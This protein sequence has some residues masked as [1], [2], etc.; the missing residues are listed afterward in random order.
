MWIFPNS[1][2]SWLKLKIQIK[3]DWKLESLSHAPGKPMN[4]RRNPTP[5][6]TNNY[7]LGIVIE[8]FKSRNRSYYR[9]NSWTMPEALQTDTVRSYP[10]VEC[11]LIL[12][13]DAKQMGVYR[14][15]CNTLQAWGI[16]LAAR[17]ELLMPDD[18]SIFSANKK[19][20]LFTPPLSISCQF[21][22]PFADRRS[23]CYEV[24]ES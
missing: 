22:L 4:I 6:E 16:N 21:L 18:F 11:K 5:W 14:W 15:S 2:I 23:E 19:W 7:N 8:N 12:T 24:K 1:F 3:E 13:G 9:W 20:L 17:Y 10:V